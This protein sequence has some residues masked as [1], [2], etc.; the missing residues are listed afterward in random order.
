M[1]YE[2][3]LVIT[4]FLMNKTD[5]GSWVCGDRVSTDRLTDGGSDRQI[6]KQSDIQ[7]MIKK[8]NNK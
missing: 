5:T 7:A 1:K 2:K 4:H 3:R 8:K 6:G